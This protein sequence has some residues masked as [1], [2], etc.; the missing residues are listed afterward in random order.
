MFISS[1][2][3]ILIKIYICYFT[4]YIKSQSSCV[5]GSNGCLECLTPYSCSV[6]MQGYYLV[7][8]SLI[9]CNPCS[10]GC[11]QCSGSSC[12]QCAHGFLTA[13][14]GCICPSGRGYNSVTKTCYFCDP[15]CQSCEPNYQY[16][17]TCK[18]GYGLNSNNTC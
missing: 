8:P 3:L 1:R 14:S 16:C 10:L 17:V 11:L 13:A 2:Y 6:C 15:T 9:I 4:V 7:S 5:T 18:A 12:S